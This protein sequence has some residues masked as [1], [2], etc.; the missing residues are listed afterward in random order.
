MFGK[1]SGSELL[2]LT[3]VGA[4]Y[5]RAEAELTQLVEELNLPFLASPMGK[6]VVSDTHPNCVGAARSLALEKADVVLF[7]GA[8]MNWMFQFGKVFSN[9]KIIQV[10]T[11]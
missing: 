5:S 7:V 8:R 1:G 3:L 11:Q 6:G 10:S 4:A 9:A 2:N